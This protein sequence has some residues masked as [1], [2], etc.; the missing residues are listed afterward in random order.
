MPVEVVVNDLIGVAVKIAHY[1]IGKIRIEACNIEAKEE[2]FGRDFQHIIQV[3]II[4]TLRVER[5]GNY[6]FAGAREGGRE[7]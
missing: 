2:P 7:V 5:L 3:S 6:H 4:G 1:L